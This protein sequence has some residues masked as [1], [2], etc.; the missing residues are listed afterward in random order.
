MLPLFL[1]QLEK[2][3]SLETGFLEDDG[4]GFFVRPEE[5]D[6]MVFNNTEGIFVGLDRS[7]AFF[8]HAQ[9]PPRPVVLWAPLKNKDT[10]RKK[11]FN[12]IGEVVFC[13]S[14]KM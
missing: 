4:Y 9:G 12:S 2:L 13:P 11:L 8:L 14:R 1:G 3:E 10:R 6:S 7:P 5:K